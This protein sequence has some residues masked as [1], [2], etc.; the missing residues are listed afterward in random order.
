MCMQK[1]TPKRKN[2]QVS[3]VKGAM[4]RF[5]MLLKKPKVIF[6][7]VKKKKKNKG[8]NLF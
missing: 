1:T 8:L 7:S 4:S 2:P 6:I 3:M 5:L